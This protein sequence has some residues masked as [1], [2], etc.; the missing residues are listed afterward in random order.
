MNTPLSKI[1]SCTNRSDL[2]LL[3]GVKPA[4]LSY[5]LYKIPDEN[6]YYSFSIP[7]RN[8]DQRQISAPIPALKMLQRRL[9]EHLY[10]CLNE[11]EY[12][13]AVDPQCVVAHG[14]KKHLSIATNG[15]HHRSKRWVFNCDI[16]EFFSS[17]NFGRVK[18]YFERNR[19]FQ[20][21]PEVALVVAQICCHEGVLPQGAPTSPII[22]N[23]I[24]SILDDRISRLANE[25]RCTYTRYADDLTFSTNMAHF[26]R[27]IAVADEKSP[28]RWRI[29]DKLLSRVAQAGFR[30][31]HEKSRMAM[32]NSRQTVTGLTVNKTVNVATTYYKMTRAMC[33]H[34]F[35]TG[36]YSSGGLNDAPKGRELAALEG[37]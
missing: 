2:A 13:E 16:E 30:I 3:L 4:A 20:L 8:G 26:P 21:Q 22:S 7:K 27:Q 28:S 15:S 35:T 9:S 36:S 32:P 17:I 25:L 6:K 12:L 14:F 37:R 31:N 5:I 34:L 29:G 18:G 23:L 11:I 19:H 1:K 24:G 33:H 10:E